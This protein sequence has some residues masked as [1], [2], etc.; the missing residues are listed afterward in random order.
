MVPGTS[1]VVALLIVTVVLGNVSAF[2]NGKPHCRHPDDFLRDWSVK[3]Q[4]NKFWRCTGFG[5]AELNDCDEGR[6]FSERYLM[7]TIPGAI[8]GDIDRPLNLIECGDDEEVDLSGPEP[9][10]AHVPCE[11]GVIVYNPEGHPQCHR[12]DTIQWCQG[13]PLEKRIAGELS[14]SKPECTT[15]EYESNRLFASEDP[16]QF[17]RCAHVNSPVTF[18]C[19]PALCYDEMSQSCVWPAN[20]RNVCSEK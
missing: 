10:C 9:F 20:W 5:T 12:E 4:P 18:N 2:N 13:A 14:C 8:I 17:Y 6:E 1:F 11:K 7:C 19:H 3:N 15:E 16:T